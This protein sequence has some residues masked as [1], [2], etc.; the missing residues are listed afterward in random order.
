MYNCIS[1]HLNGVSN[2][3]GL[4]HDGVTGRWTGV[5]DMQRDVW[6]HDKSKLN[7]IA[8]PE[9]VNAHYLF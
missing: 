5:T 7:S 9:L 1:V 3:H 6:P 4:L 2:Y 8:S